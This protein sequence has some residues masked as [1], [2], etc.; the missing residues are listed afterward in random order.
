MC[1]RINYSRDSIQCIAMSSYW[2]RYC[3][4][5]FKHHRRHIYSHL[6]VVPASLIAEHP[7][8]SLQSGI[9]CSLLGPACSLLGSAHSNKGTLGALDSGEHSRIAF[10]QLQQATIPLCSE[11]DGCSA[12]NDAGTTRRCEYGAWKDRNSINS[13]NCSWLYTVYYLCCN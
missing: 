7:S 1:E 13:N 9:T 4:D 8:L 5:P 6:R 10:R 2:S 11:R 3:C 12:I